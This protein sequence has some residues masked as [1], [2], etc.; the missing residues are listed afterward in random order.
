M[1]CKCKSAI[2][3]QA[4]EDLKTMYLAAYSALCHCDTAADGIL[5]RSCTCI[6]REDL[7]DRIAILNTTYKLLLRHYEE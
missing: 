3:D 4:K 7:I 2:L 1:A 5:P 6:D